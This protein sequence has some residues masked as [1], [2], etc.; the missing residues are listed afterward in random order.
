MQTEPIYIVKS[1]GTRE[2]FDIKKLEYSLKRAGAN[3]TTVQEVS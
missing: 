2:A 3:S 1:D